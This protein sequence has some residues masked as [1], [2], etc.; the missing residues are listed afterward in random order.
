MSCDMFSFLIYGN[1]KKTSQRHVQNVEQN[2]TGARYDASDPQ[3]KS[4]FVNKT[5]CLEQAGVTKLFQTQ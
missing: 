1:K 2:K 3:N 4:R 5:K